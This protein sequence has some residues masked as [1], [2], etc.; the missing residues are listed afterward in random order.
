MKY[1]SKI[2]VDYKKKKT[3]RYRHSVAN[4]EKLKTLMG[5]EQKTHSTSETG[6][7]TTM[8]VMPGKIK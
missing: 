5:K 2:L 1:S 3:K 6:R 7:K 8:K 4:G